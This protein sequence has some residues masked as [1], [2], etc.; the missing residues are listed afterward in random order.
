LRVAVARLSRYT[1]G[2]ITVGDAAT[3]DLRVT[4]T[5]Y[6]DRVNAWLAGIEAVLPVRVE[7]VDEHHI[8]I[9]AVR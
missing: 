4:G 5:A 1:E 3:G 6:V 7:K 2:E 9:T 8:F